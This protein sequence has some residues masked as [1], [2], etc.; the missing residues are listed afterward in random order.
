MSELKRVARQ[1]RTIELRCLG[2]S[3]PKIAETLK[4]EKIKSSERTVF[5]DLRSA[6]AEDMIQELLRIQNRDITE[7]QDVEVRLKYR[8]RILG[9]LMPKI[10]QSH[11][12]LDV[13]EPRPRIDM[14]KFSEAERAKILETTR[15]IFHKR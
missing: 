15:L 2:Y 11:T 5:R 6:L 4:E 8:D 13:P 10:I 3:I 14:K 9:K 1:R 7:A 12:E